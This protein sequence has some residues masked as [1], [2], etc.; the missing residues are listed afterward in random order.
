MIKLPER[1][2]RF[3][4]EPLLPPTAFSISRGQVCGVRRAGKEKRVGAHVIRPLPAG[5]LVPAFDRPNVAD[6]AAVDAAIKDAARRL[7]APAGAVSL[8]IP[9]TCVKTAILTFEALPSSPTEREA[10]L[11]WRLAKTLPLKISDL[12]LS[13]DVVPSNGGARAFCVLALERI[14]ADYE[15]AFA[16]AGLRVRQIG[17]PTPHLLGLIPRT[18]PADILVAGIEDDHLTLFAVCSGAPFLFRVKTLV[19]GAAANAGSFWVQVAAEVAT[20]IHFLEDREKKRLETVWIRSAVGATP[21][22][23][24]AIEARAGCPVRTL[25]FSAPAVAGPKEQAILAPL[26]GQVS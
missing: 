11:R 16:K 21:E 25:A 23:L 10:V 8:L 4:T 24:A 3:F 14:V 17:L 1:W 18:G 12:R 2:T 19:L 6:G 20:T 9:E 13:F 26:V 22:D 7:G 5:A 15:Q